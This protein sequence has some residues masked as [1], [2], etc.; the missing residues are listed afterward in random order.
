MAG[1]FPGREFL[2]NGTS[3]N[4]VV[5]GS[6]TPVEFKYQPAPGT[7]FTAYGT[8]FNATGTGTISNPMEFWDF[9]ALPNGIKL[10]MKL[11]G[12]EK[13][14]G[15]IIKNNFHLIEYIG[16]EFLGKI[17][18]TNNVVRGESKFQPALSFNGNLGDWIK[19]VIQDNL[20][21]PASPHIQNMTVSIR[22]SLIT[23]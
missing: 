20:I 16:A 13:D 9:P 5:N 12:V 15:P 2:L 1:L 11:N 10:I 6:L 21:V 3:K 22:G 19:I 18:G 7:I 23:L 17:I 14:F 4:M 8:I